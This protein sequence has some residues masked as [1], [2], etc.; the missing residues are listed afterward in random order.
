MGTI[1]STTAKYAI[2]F[3]G[4][5][6]FHII[7]TWSFPLVDRDEPRFAE[8]SREMMETGDYIVPHFNNQ[9]RLDKPPLAYWAQIASYKIFGQNDFA[10]RF[11]SAV[12][13]ALAAMLILVWGR[14]IGGDR[15]GWWAAIIFTLSLQTFMH[16]KAAVADMWLVLFV[17][18]AHRAGYELLQEKTTS[19]AE[20]RTSDAQWVWWLTFY[21]S[22]ALGFLA[23]GPIAWTP[24]L[25]IAAFKYFSRDVEVG[26]RFKF[27]RGILLTL[28]I[29]A[30]WGVPAM[31]QTHGEF[32]RIGIGRH[33]V[34]RSFSAMESH[35]SNSLGVYL[36]LLPFYFVTIFASFFPWSIRLPALT[37]KLW[38]GSDKNHLRTSGYGGQ[39]DIYLI[40]GAAVIFLIFTLIKTKLPHYTLPAFPLLSLSLARHWSENK[41]ALFKRIATATA[42]LWL[43][44]ALIVPL[45]VAQ[46]FPA[47]ALFQKSRDTLRPEMEFG[48]VDF[49]EPSLVWYFRSSVHGWMTPL[50]QQTA[51]SFMEQVGPRFVILPTESVTAAFP[52]P[53][54]TWKTFSTSGI[55]IAKGKHV[56]LSLVLKPD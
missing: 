56:D 18:L 7:G 5:I 46:S 35:G 12:A 29:V 40:C 22:L 48:S 16:A 14:Q 50:N 43:G 2:L 34:G 8:A 17:T 41:A 39:V 20:R 28:A 3:F 30:L 26:S 51:A 38:R 21:I 19:N 6:A 31:I 33:V 10:A 37:K 49:Q 15:V 54:S 47:Y 9:L 1:N 32:L 52:N 44:I 11:P 27:V 24:L 4:C 42:C 36:L 55:N 53:P 23:K 13:A 45:L 25:T